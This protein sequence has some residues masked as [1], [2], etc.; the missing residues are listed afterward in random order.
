MPPPQPA[1]FACAICGRQYQH[2]SH[3][4]RHEV[5]HFETERFKC[6]HCGKVFRRRDVWRKH[7][8]CCPKNNNHDNPPPARRG[9]KPRACDGCFRSKLSCDGSSPCARCKSRQ[10][11]CAY[12]RVHVDDTDTTPGS[13]STNAGHSTTP[14]AAAP[15]TE[16][17][18]S[19]IPVSFLLS[20]TNPEAESMHHVFFDEPY[21]DEDAAGVGFQE[22]PADTGLTQD[23]V[24]GEMAFFPLFFSQLYAEPFPD[25][26]SFH[27][28]EANTSTSS[29][30]TLDPAFAPIVSD[31]ESL[32]HT[33]VATVPTY[34]GTFD[35]ALAKQVF[36][37]SNREAFVA[38]YF[39]H[40]HR[41]LPIIHRPSFHADTCSPALLLAMCLCGAQYCA[42]RDSVLAIPRFF[43][44][45]DEYIF[46]ILEAQVARHEK[47]GITS[48]SSETQEERE[49]HDTLRAA[50]LIHGLLFMINDP[51]ARKRNLLVRRPLLVDA[52]RRL[53]L[54][55]ASQTQADWQQ[56]G[57]FHVPGLMTVLEMTGDMPC[58]TELWEARDAAEFEALVASK[59]K[60]CWRRSASLRDCMDA[61]MADDWSGIG[62]FPLKYLSTLDL[63]ILTFAI[64][65]LIGTARFMSLLQTSTP[66][67]QRATDRWQELWRAVTG[68][69]DAEDLRMSGL[70]RHSGE[71]NWLAKALL[72]HSLA[73]K[74]RT[75]PYFQRIGHETPNALHEL[76]QELRGAQ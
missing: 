48:T 42:P 59:G 34:D 13:S 25:L 73:G 10:V 56:T 29:P 47:G 41:E 35:T 52:V 19:K 55:R 16:T 63:F 70:V 36:T 40:T 74:D 5:T 18:K 62:R 31:L 51:V 76:L 67:L 9:K 68:Q 14:S 24:I 22:Q 4:R 66:A 49:L 27:E 37:L 2:S 33:L 1:G 8:I 38:S 65:S 69:L 53:E 60:A 44:I 50:L 32:H 11:T 3:L 26:S 58:L 75:T 64:H 45:T 72:E 54:T 12:T 21:R 61:L 57:L 15:S 20:F 46:H 71:F 17:D 23:A 30:E 6:V 39:C 28:T 7:Y 43:R